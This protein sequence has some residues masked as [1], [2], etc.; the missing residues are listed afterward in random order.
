MFDH[1]SEIMVDQFGRPSFLNGRGRVFILLKTEI[2]K[3]IN[4]RIAYELLLFVIDRMISYKTVKRPYSGPLVIMILNNL[5]FDTLSKKGIRKCLET[6]DRTGHSLTVTKHYRSMR[7][8][9][10]RIR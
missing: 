9:T 5:F 6:G 3:L 10:A 8:E 2:M 1:T 7:G 4:R